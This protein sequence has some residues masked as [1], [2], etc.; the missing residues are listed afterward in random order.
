MRI[1]VQFDVNK[2]IVDMNN[3]PETL[4]ILITEL[5]VKKKNVSNEEYRSDP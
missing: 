3:D 1:Q 2:E 5:C 4:A